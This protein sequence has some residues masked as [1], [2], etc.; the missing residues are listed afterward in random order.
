MVA[1]GY[2]ELIHLIYWVSPSPF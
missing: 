2:E 1:D